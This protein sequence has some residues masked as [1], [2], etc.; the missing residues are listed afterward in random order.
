MYEFCINNR[1]YSI[2]L[3][4]HIDGLNENVQPILHST[5]KNNTIKQA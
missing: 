3:L 2:C 4:Y 1:R 5:S